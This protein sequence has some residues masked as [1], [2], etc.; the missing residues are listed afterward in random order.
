MIW[1]KQHNI[2]NVLNSNHDSELEQSALFESDE[3]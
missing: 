3:K 1:M 2:L